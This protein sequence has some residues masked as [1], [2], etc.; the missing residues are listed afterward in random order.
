MGAMT[1]VIASVVSSVLG[2]ISSQLGIT[3]TM[4]EAFQQLEESGQMPPEQ[5][6]VLMGMVDNPMFYIGLVL[7]GLIV[8][9]VLGTAGGAIGASM[10]KKGGPLPEA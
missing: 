10:F 5:L 8:G 3:P 9:A 7:V 1:G 6:D 2:Y 4:E